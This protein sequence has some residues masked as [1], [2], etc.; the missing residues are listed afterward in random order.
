MCLASADPSIQEQ[1]SV[2]LDWSYLLAGALLEVEA[3]TQRTATKGFHLK[4]LVEV[5]G[6]SCSL[7]LSLHNF[8]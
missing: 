2:R 5:V 4:A 8:T 3:E 7:Q 6:L 1:E